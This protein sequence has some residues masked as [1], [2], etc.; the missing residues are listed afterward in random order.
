MQTPSG[1]FV[2]S[3]SARTGY[4]KVW[5]R[6]NCYVALGFDRCG[7]HETA[8][9]IMHGILDILQK[10]KDKI[11]W[12]TKNKPTE[13]Y[14]FIHARYHPDTLE[15]F[16]EP[17]GNKQNDAIGLILYM[18]G[19]MHLRHGGVLRGKDDIEMMQLL[20]N[21]LENI[22]Y[23]EMPDNGMWEES[24]E[25]HASSIGACVAGLMQIEYHVKVPLELIE[26][27]YQALD[28]LLPRESKSR[29][30]DLALLSLIYPYNILKPSQEHEIV[31]NVEYYLKKNFGV[32]RYRGD[33]Y[34]SLDS[35]GHQE[36]EWT[37][38]YPWLAIIYEQMGDHASALDDL[39]ATKRLLHE[40]GLPELYYSGTKT[41]NDNSPLAWA[42]AMYA[43]ALH[44]IKDKSIMKP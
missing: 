37:M 35:N 29:F 36:A 4:F 11:V 19:D 14:Q 16:H 10:H 1:L 30:C 9:K 28:E 40:G 20:V 24:E 44:N 21:Y 39:C 41:P 6:D 17:W 3:P 32:I 5:L 15:E 8:T 22:V 23:W 18:I 38:G 42:E 12:A 7:D 33:K 25:L 13:P 26:K 2:A 34:Y 27:G 43:I 31:K